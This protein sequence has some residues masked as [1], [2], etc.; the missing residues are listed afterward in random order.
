MENKS[1][2]MQA[3]LQMVVIPQETL[4]EM[5]GNLETLK[6]MVVGLV[7]SKT[8]NELAGE[9][10]ESEQARQFLGVA[11]KTWQAY[12]NNRVI[13]FSQYGRKI[14]VKRSD[15]E[16]FLQSCRVSK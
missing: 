6:E 8:T 3:G 13:P 12:R 1:S 14:Y 9:W 10:L 16:A 15:L 4:D 5:M 2:T 7:Q 11:P